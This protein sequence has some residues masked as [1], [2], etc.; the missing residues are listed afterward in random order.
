MSFSSVDTK[1]RFYF[2]FGLNIS[3]YNLEA[4]R[5]EAYC[6]A[7][8]GGEGRS[9]R[10]FV[11]YDNMH[12]VAGESERERESSDFIA[13]GRSTALENAMNGGTAVSFSLPLPSVVHSF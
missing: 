1:I 8:G 9:R 5:G 10:R 3:P 13:L 4:S 11:C 6:L 2:F 7:R 12:R